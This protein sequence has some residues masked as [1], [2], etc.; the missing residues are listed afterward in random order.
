MLLEQLDSYPFGDY[1]DSADALQMSV[2]HVA[3]SRGI[4]RDKPIWL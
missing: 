1:V 2:E 4:V 3:R